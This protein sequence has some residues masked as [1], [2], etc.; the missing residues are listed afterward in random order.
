M[1]DKSDLGPE[2]EAG[3]VPENNSAESE[4]EKIVLEPETET[5]VS[6]KNSRKM[7]T[8]MLEPPTFIS[9]DKPFEV[10]KKDLQRWSRLTTLDKKLQAEMIV[11]K[12][13]NHPSNIKEKIT[14]QLGDTLED[15]DKGVEELLAF[16]EGI[17]Q[18]D[19]MA[20]AWEKYTNFEKFKCDDKTTIKKF[21]A[22]W[23]N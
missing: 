16:L 1:D 9:E 11:Y 15:N 18:K 5:V 20:D 10:Y 6:G 14:T 7:T 3:S 8:N 21:I 2:K 17:Y 23:E 4:I 22:D 13:E 12:L 19:S